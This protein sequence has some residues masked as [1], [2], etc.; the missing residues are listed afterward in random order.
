M[1]REVVDALMYP[2]LKYPK[3]K[4]TGEP[5]LNRNPTMKLRFHFGRVVTMLRFTEWIE[6][7]YLPPIWKGAE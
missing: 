3:N 1:S 2:I 4:E 5:D 7:S 6:N